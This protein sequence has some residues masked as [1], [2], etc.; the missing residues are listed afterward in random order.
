MGAGGGAKRR[1]KPFL[2]DRYQT[3]QTINWIKIGVY[4]MITYITVLRVYH[5]LNL[6]LKIFLIIVTL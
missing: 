3:W 6:I 5:L 4:K 2:G 1:Y